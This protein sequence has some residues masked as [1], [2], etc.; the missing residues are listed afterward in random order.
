MRN[1]IYKA[2]IKLSGILSLIFIAAHASAYELNQIIT[3]HHWFVDVDV[4]KSYDYA[5][6]NTVVPL[7]G[8]TGHMLFQTDQ[9]ATP[10]FFSTAIGYLW[11]LQTDYLPFISVGLQYHYT[12]PIVMSGYIYE[13]NLDNS[14]NLTHSLYSR[15]QVKQQSCSLQTKMD[16][17]RWQNLMP[18]FAFGLGASW[19][20]I[21]NFST[22]AFDPALDDLSFLASTN[23][24]SDFT[25]NLG[26]GID[27]LV[28]PDLWLS[29]G[30]TY[31]SFGK[32][33]IGQLLRYTNFVTPL[34]PLAAFVKNANLHAHSIVFSARY[35]FA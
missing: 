28:N 29:L 8:S 15:Y 9:A 23:T 25:Y 7:A 18:Y 32:N 24:S 16:L 27:Y 22:L 10:P 26:V 4:G 6:S 13:V 31:D 5:S 17:Y 19:N 14:I 35:L 33:E 20:R 3:P 11:K 34:T 12:T 30:Y 1:I 21:N 2:V